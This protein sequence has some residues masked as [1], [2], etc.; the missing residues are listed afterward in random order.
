MAIGHQCIH[1]GEGFQPRPQNPNQQYCSKPEC[2]K[3]RKR[4]W[5]RQKLQNDP[6]Y[7]ENQRDAARRWREHNP[8]YWRN[9]RSQH[10]DYTSR[11]RR[12][13][14]QRNQKRRRNAG[15]GGGV[16][17]NMDASNTLNTVRSGR[18]QLIP[19]ATDGMVVIANMD[20]SI[21]EISVIQG[22]Y[23]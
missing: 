1:C 9:Y 10:Q 18:Y 23:P 8:D 20:A 22:G 5:Q 12:Q 16:I 14:H 6:E 4:H 11:N 2:Q 17:A 7:R 3:A 15:S 13:Q 21:V 19:I